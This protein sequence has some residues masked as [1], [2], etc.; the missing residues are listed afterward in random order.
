MAAVSTAE[1]KVPKSPLTPA[2]V[3]VVWLRG[4]VE[5]AID[6]EVEVEVEVVVVVAA[7]VVVVVVL[8]CVSTS[9]S[10]VSSLIGVKWVGEYWSLVEYGDSGPSPSGMEIS[11]GSIGVSMVEQLRVTLGGGSSS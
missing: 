2:L 5:V 9:A 11:M 10:E 3:V 7:P 6:V 4:S 1:V 8:S